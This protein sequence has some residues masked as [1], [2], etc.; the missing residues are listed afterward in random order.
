MRVVAV[1]LSVTLLGTASAG[2]LTHR[3]G[4]GESEHYRYSYE[5]NVQGQRKAIAG[6][7]QLTFSTVSP[8]LKGTEIRTQL[9]PAQRAVRT[10]TISRD[11]YLTFDNDKFPSHNYLSYDAHQ[12]CPMPE[13]IVVGESWSCKT[14]T[15]GF[16]HGGDAHVRVVSADETSATLEIDGVDTDA[17]RS[18]RHRE[19]G[20]TYTSRTTAAWHETV[21]FKNG[22]VQSIVRDQTLRSTIANLTLETRIRAKIDRI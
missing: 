4:S 7:F 9:T 15:V 11:G 20:R 10:F 19:T 13:T 17:P 22:L 12:Y 18:E 6:E 8:V 1:A 14:Q 5:F 3:F 21:Q 16:F 2:P